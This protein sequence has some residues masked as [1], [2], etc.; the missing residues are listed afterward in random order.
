MTNE[1]KTNPGDLRPE[2]PALPEEQFAKLL[3]L[4]W[5]E[6]EVDQSFRQDWLRV[7]DKPA[8]LER[9]R[10]RLATVIR[11]AQDAQ[12]IVKDLREAGFD[13]RFVTHLKR[14]GPEAAAAVPILLSWLPRI[15]NRGVKNI[16]LSVLEAKWTPHEAVP[17]LVEEF[18]S[19][20]QQGD[21]KTA[22]YVGSALERIVDDRDYDVLAE[23]ARDPRNGAARGMIVLALGKMRKHPEA[24]DLVVEHLDDER[25]VWFALKALR[26][27][28]G[29]KSTRARVAAFRH[30]IEPFAA[31][32]KTDLRNEAKAILAKLDKAAKKGRSSD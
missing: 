22:W 14:L 1:D 7:L 5:T 29:R 3:E 10:R 15:Q 17:V 24:V 26:K 2:N 28:A 27:L 30:R 12:P 18:K 20:V 13:V 32:K 23:L 19:L 8:A 25:L 31:S 11:N 6:E 4:G 16:I 9:E 21:I